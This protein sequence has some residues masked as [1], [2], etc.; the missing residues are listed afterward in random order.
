MKPLRV[1]ILGA[2][3]IAARH[4]AAIAAYLVGQKLI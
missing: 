4:A 1:G 3:G 2:G